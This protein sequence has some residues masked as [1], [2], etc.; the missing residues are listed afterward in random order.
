MTKAQFQTRY[1]TTNL[2]GYGAT[3]PFYPSWGRSCPK[4]H[5]TPGERGNAGFPDFILYTSPEWHM[6]AAVIEVK[7]WWSYDNR[8]VAEIFTHETA[9][10]FDGH[11]TWSNPNTSAIILKQVS[12]LIQ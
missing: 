2:A 10:P 5:L 8:N 1:E 11:F 9:R 12:L 3:I 7:T 4:A 6:H